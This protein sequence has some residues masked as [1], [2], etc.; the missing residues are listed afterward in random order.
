MIWTNA[1][2]K[3]DTLYH[4]ANPLKNLKKL[5]E[6]LSNHESCGCLSVLAN[7][8]HTSSLTSVCLYITYKYAPKICIIANNATILLWPHHFCQSILLPN[9]QH[10]C[11][12]S[13]WDRGRQ[14]SD[15]HGFSCRPSST[16]IHHHMP[17]INIKDMNFYTHQF[18][19]DAFLWHVVLQY[20]TLTNLRSPNA[21]VGSKD[22]VK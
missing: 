4:V 13:I 9:V 21:G 22:E 20:L 3:P 18:M 14:P 16:I 10:F 17:S 7:R 1:I 8:N 6:W 11:M 12:P 15:E 19:F 5:F 2:Q